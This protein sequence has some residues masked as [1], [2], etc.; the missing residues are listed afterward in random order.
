MSTPTLRERLADILSQVYDDRPVTELEPTEAAPHYRAAG[1]VLAVLP[2][3]DTAAPARPPGD[4]L[5]RIAEAMNTLAAHEGDDA[6]ELK[7]RLAAILDGPPLPLDLSEAEP[8][9]LLTAD[10]IRTRLEERLVANWPR[11]NH[12]GYAHDI[13]DSLMNDI[14]LIVTELQDQA[15]G[16]RRRVDRTLEDRDQARA[17]AAT[18]EEITAEA[19]R[20]LRNGE[21]GRALA[22]LQSDGQPLGPCGIPLFVDDISCARPAGHGGAHSDD[23]DYT[24]PPH[25]CPALPDQLYVVV[26]ERGTGQARYRE[27]DLNGIFS[28]VED[29]NSRARDL[30]LELTPGDPTQ[31]T[32]TADGPVTLA[33][34]PWGDFAGLIEVAALDLDPHLADA[35]REAAEA[36]YDPDHGRD[37]DDED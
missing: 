24:E 5:S 10:R 29:A 2:L 4:T 35:E 8:P 31:M 21:Y 25:A 34:R 6:L 18:L 36:E 13:A 9:R 33:C 28:D 27:L 37:L 16:W 12:A 30:V 14:L 3:Y 23:P 17:L 26:A 1:A 22:V 7:L 32:N 15:S 11:M 19:T 20:L